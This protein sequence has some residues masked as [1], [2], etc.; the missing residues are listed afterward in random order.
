[1]IDADTLADALVEPR[2][3]LEPNRAA[4]ADQLRRQ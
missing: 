4:P 3:I 1:M 2:K